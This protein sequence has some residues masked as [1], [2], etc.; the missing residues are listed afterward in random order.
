MKNTRFFLFLFL[1]LPIC[2][3][4]QKSA[5][6][7]ATYFG[8]DSAVT[9][10]SGYFGT[11][12]ECVADT[13]GNIYLSGYTYS[14]SGIATSGAY[15]TS[16][17]SV[18]GDAFLAKFNSAGKLLW[19]TYLGGK[20]FDDA[21]GVVIDRSGNVYI[22][23]TTSSTSGIATTGAYQTSGDS[24]WDA[25][26]LA[27]FSPTGNLL[28]ATYFGDSDDVFGMT[29]DTSGNAFISGFTS[30]AYGIATKGAYQITGTANGDAFLAKFNP[31][32]SLLW[33]TYYGG[34]G[35]GYSNAVTTDISGNVY[36][37]GATSSDS[38]VATSGAYQ[39]TRNNSS[40][41]FLAKF[42]ASGSLI[43]GTYYEGYW[44]NGIATD[45]HGNIYITGLVYSSSGLATSGA[46]Q[47]TG[48]SINGS[49]FLAKFNP[50][51]GLLWATYYGGTGST[52]G[53][54]IAT[55]VY[56]NVY[57]SDYT[58]SR[59]G[60]AT[61]GAFL[62]SNTGGYEAYLAKFNPSGN[63]AWGTYYGGNRAVYSQCVTV[64]DSDNIYISGVTNSISGIATSG[65]YQTSG[66]EAQGDAFLAKFRIPTFYNDA[67][68]SSILSPGRSVCADSIPVEVRLKNYGPDT[69]K[70][71]K[72]IC[73][74]NNE[75]KFNYTWAG[76]LLSG[77][78]TSV[79]LGNYSFKPGIDT[80]K[81]W[82]EPIGFTDTVPGNDTATTIITVNPLPQ[83]K[84]NI[85][86]SIFCINSGLQLLN[87]G[88]AG[89]NW[90]GNGMNGNYFDPFAAA[91]HRTD[92]FHEVYEYTDTITGCAN[93]ISANL[94]VVDTP[95]VKVTVPDSGCA[96]SAI[97]FSATVSIASKHIWSFGDGGTDTSL[98]PV[99]KY[100]KPGVY[101]IT[102]GVSSKGGCYDS[103][104]RT[105][106]IDS[107]CSVATGI[108]VSTENPS[109]S[110]YPNPFTNQT[111]ITAVVKG[112]SAVGLTIY[113]MTG[114][115]VVAQADACVGGRKSGERFEYI[116]D[117]SQYGSGIYIV[118]LTMGNEVVTREIVRIR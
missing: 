50:S 11:A 8:G 29:I 91:L 22:S 89:G 53:E 104:Y 80:I 102:F 26:F 27:K 19:A 63:L 115:V 81:A 114:R 49:A 71:V 28:W 42:S 58:A 41:V 13:S 54:G 98:N 99:H 106:Y 56:G 85:T 39:T 24:T 90:T 3:H 48:D 67:G 23:G 55:D 44:G 69:L 21:D 76:N 1:L 82:T 101:T 92:S 25:A 12:G 30:S 107:P 7:W 51:G 40:D 116:F 74:I 118:K 77:N 105:I 61:A 34:N 36:M 79:S 57:L 108:P 17:D 60:I 73:S 32:G 59:T 20:G 9:G 14:L 5:L 66:N 96:D 68:I 113:D 75:I 111:T 31:S 95:I 94:Y 47:V 84:T 33:A 70:A 2:A 45:L 43:W 46:Y 88:P 110:V 117:A 72:I 109:I 18:N 100:T 4:A 87:A 35:G 10:T 112:N 86:D 15:Q 103:I 64:G 97:H 62:T 37:T 93:S 52:F 38:G 16:G 65:T 78:S 6:Q 83:L